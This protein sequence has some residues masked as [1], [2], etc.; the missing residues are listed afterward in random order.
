MVTA[1]QR[2]YSTTTKTVLYSSILGKSGE[3]FSSAKLSHA[4]EMLGTYAAKLLGQP[5]RKEFKEIRVKTF[6]TFKTIS[7]FK[8]N[9]STAVQWS[10]QVPD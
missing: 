10:L 4:W 7:P 6:P 3:H 9:I 1:N 8:L 2:F 5:W